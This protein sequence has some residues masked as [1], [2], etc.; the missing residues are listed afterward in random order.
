MFMKEIT[1]DQPK[2]VLQVNI[3][4]ESYSIPLAG[5]LPF[6]DALKLRK[7][8][9]EERLEFV[10]DFIKRYIPDEVFNTLTADAVMKI[11]SAWSEASQESQGVSP[12]ES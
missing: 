6:T 4:S 5:S 9:S 11:F 1:L 12:G 2:E 7:L 10:V 8:D 3:G